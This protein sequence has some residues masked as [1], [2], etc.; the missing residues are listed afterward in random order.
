[1][2]AD[3]LDKAIAIVES[4]DTG[5]FHYAALELR[6][7]IEHHVYKKLAY[8]AKRHGE[9][10]LYAKWQPN[11]AMKVLCQLEP[12][13]DQ[14]YT[15]SMAPETEPGK[16]GKNFVQLGQHEALSTSWI[17]KHYNKLGSYLH[18]Q[19]ESQS[20]REAPKEYLEEVIKELRR[21]KKS[22]LISSLAATVHF[23]CSL[24]ETPVVCCVDALPHLGEVVCPSTSCNATF[25]PEQTEGG[26]G[27]NLNAV[28]FECPECGNEQP[29]LT[30]E[31]GIGTRIACSQCKEKFVVKG[32]TWQI[33]KQE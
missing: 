31:I 9:K 7:A 10:L 23:D 15:L 27:F 17:T 32:H 8:H 20:R 13:A 12:H 5:Q 6:L 11:K 22:N 1:M 29:V 28:D 26:W 18:L 16:P 25:T 21:A 3:Y 30:S 4:G 14:S 33:A 24:C 2:P 19:T